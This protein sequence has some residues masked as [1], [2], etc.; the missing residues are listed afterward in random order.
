MILPPAPGPTFILTPDE[1]AVVRLV[2]DG[3][4]NP[5]IAARLFMSVPSVK[6]HLRR[7]YAKTGTENRVT[8]ALWWH[9]TR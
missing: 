2:H 5:E 3:L 9:D 6:L 7:A 1:M 8:L 4:T